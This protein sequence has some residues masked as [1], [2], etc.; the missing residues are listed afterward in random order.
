MLIVFGQFFISSLHF[1]VESNT[2]CIPSSSNENRDEKRSTQHLPLL[3]SKETGQCLCQDSVP[4]S[5]KGPGSESFQCVA[6]TVPASTTQ[7][8]LPHESS[9]SPDVHE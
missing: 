4:F 2:V 7:L 8:L 9:H 3:N 5:Y 1:T 6:Y